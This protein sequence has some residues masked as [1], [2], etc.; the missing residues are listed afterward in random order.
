[1]HSIGAHVHREPVVR[2]ASAADHVAWAPAKQLPESVL[3]LLLR[4]TAQSCEVQ[5]EF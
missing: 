3:E 2:L 5:I 4:I 1:M